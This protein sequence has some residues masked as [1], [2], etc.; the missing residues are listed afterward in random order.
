[1]FVQS[2]T[3][4]QLYIHIKLNIVSLIC[5]FGYTLKSETSFELKSHLPEN[6][7]FKHTIPY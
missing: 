1:M 7:N 6:T 3:H 4:R 2:N 5:L